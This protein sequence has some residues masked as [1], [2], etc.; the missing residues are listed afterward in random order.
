MPKSI[1]TYKKILAVSSLILLSGYIP[2]AILTSCSRQKLD[3]VI[4]YCDLSIKSGEIP[5]Q[6]S[7][8]ITAYGTNLIGD[9]VWGGIEIG[10]YTEYSAFYGGENDSVLTITNNNDSAYDLNFSNITVTNNHTQKNITQ[11]IC[12]DTGAIDYSI[13]GDTTISYQQSLVITATA[14]HPSGNFT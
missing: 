7:L 3:T 4:V 9:Y 11:N 1:F 5:Y 12:C 8:T 14:L 10:D 6:Q 2:V 13:T